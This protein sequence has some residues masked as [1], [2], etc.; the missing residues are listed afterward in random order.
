MVDTHGMRAQVDHRSTNEILDALI[1]ASIPIL[2]FESE[3][4]NL[5]DAFLP[6]TEGAVA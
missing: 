1:H 3:G 6:L 5:L 2:S 4:G